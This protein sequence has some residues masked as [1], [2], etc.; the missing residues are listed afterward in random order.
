MKVPVDEQIIYNQ[1]DTNPDA[2]WSLMLATGYLKPV[3]AMSE[4]EAS[5]LNSERMY[6]LTLT[7][8]EVRRMFSRM[9]QGW[10]AQT[11]GLS[12][13]AQTMLQGDVWGMNRYLNDIMLT[14]MSSFDGG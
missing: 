1:R 8:W 13:F 5:D 6:T 12:K 9:I 4:K 7:N 11:G 3:Y 10:F 14:C 2:V